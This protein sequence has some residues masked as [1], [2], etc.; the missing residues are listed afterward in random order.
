M[1]MQGSSRNPQPINR[2]MGTKPTIPASPPIYL[3]FDPI[4]PGWP[5]PDGGWIGDTDQ[6]GDSPQLPELSPRQTPDN[7]WSGG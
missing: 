6:P 2:T 5:T 3:D 7:T 1:T 4:L